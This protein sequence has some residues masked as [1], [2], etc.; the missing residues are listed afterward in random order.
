[1][2]KTLFTIATFSLFMTGIA[3][4]EKPSNHGTNPDSTNQQKSN[5]NTTRTSKTIKVDLDKGEKKKEKKGEVEV[6]KSGGG[7]HVKLPFTLI[8]DKK[9]EVRSKK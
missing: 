6:K 3:Q 1:M 2:K 8:P 4:N 7:Q 9:R 5:Y